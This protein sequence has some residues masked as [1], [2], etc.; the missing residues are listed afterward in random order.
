MYKNSSGNWVRLKD[1]V[2][3]ELKDGPGLEKRVVAKFLSG[4]VIVQI[5]IE[6]GLTD[7]AQA[8]LDGMVYLSGQKERFTYTEVQRGITRG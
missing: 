5:D 4:G 2:T 6:G 1:A 8:H 3:L 7:N